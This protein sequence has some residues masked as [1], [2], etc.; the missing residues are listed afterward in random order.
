MES[1]IIGSVTAAL[2]LIFGYFLGGRG[3]SALRATNTFLQE[4]VEASRAMSGSHTAVEQLVGLLKADIENLR[5]ATER[6]ERD[7]ATSVGE[8]KTQLTQ[9][10]ESY[11]AINESTRTIASALNRG[12][13]RG[14]W[15]EMQ[16]ELMLEDA[17]FIEGTHFQ[18]QS[19]QQLDDGLLRPDVT[20]N[21]PDAT[22]L[23]IDSKFPF[24]AYWRAVESH[25]PDEANLHFKQH[26]RDVL[27]HANALAKKGYADAADGPSLVLLFMPLDSIFFA[28]IDADP[29]LQQ[30]CYQQSVVLVCPTMLLGTLRAIS[31]G[32]QR[33]ELA[34]NAQRI[35]DTA[36]S[37]LVRMSKLVTNINKLGSALTTATTA[38]NDFTKALDNSVLEDA[39]KISDLGVNVAASLAGPKEVDA[40]VRDFRGRVS[41]IA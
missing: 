39:R 32:W 14:H 15:G 35:S 40:V 7:R 21:L 25:N 16:L 8:I 23:H 27:A 10:G 2:G 6:A 33:N 31:F 1:I 5:S 29:Q 17:G 22:K 38:Y 18:R 11:S 37:L 41:E 9:F 30:K 19:S 20:L 28:A 3:T 24:D 4:Q 26:A 12:P 36:R 34:V 13:A